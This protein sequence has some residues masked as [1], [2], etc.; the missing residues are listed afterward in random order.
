MDP[1]YCFAGPGGCSVCAEVE[2]IQKKHKLMNGTNL[3]LLVLLL[4]VLVFGGY[5]LL[6]FF[7]ILGW[8][9]TPKQQTTGCAP[10]VPVTVLIPVRNE[11]AG[12]SACLEAVLHQDY[13]EELIR[14]IVIDDDSEDQSAQIIQDVFK[15]YP[16]R[17][18]RYLHLTGEGGGSGKKAALTLGHTFAM[19]GLVVCTDGDC[20]MGKNW[21]RSL[22]AFYEEKKPKLIL[23]PVAFHQEQ[24]WFERMQTLEFAGLLMVTGGSAGRNKPLMCNGANLAYTKAVFE[25][26]GGYTGDTLASGDDVLLMEKVRA[27]YPE[28]IS[29]LKSSDAV[30]YTHPQHSLSNFMQ[31]RR[32]WASKFNAYQGKDIKLTALIVYLCNF[33]FLFGPVIT[34]LFPAFGIVYLILAGGKLII[35]FLFLF[36]AISFIQRRSLAWLYLPEQL[37][38]SLYVVISGF[39]AFRKGFEWKGR[40]IDK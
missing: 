7:Q 18:T 32:R 11:E 38:Y 39:L 33:L 34:L 20:V 23:G 24:G 16:G 12:V 13:P 31:Q 22:A 26:A 40:R 10:R 2:S 37:I 25:E 8:L 27:L 9:R 35:D 36:L 29:F 5:F 3:H 15:T 1:E 6:L 14:I 4:F 28:G 30:V 21:L 19:D 17:A